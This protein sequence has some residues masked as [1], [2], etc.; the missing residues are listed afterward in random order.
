MHIPAWILIVVFLLIV[1]L[2][3]LV[4]RLFYRIRRLRRL[5]MKLENPE[6]EEKVET[7]D[8]GGAE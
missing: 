4:F 5:I 2:T 7:G 1:W 8:I 3:A 6:Y